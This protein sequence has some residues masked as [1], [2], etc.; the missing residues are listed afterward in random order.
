MNCEKI[1]TK[2]LIHVVADPFFLMYYSNQYSS[3]AEEVHCAFVY[4]H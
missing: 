2:Q 4:M 3:M 1:N